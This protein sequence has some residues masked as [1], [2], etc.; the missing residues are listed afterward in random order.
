MAAEIESYVTPAYLYRYRPL[1]PELK[2]GG[3][4]RRNRLLEELDAI[5]RHYLF[6]S[7]YKAMN[8]PMEGMYKSTRRA[9]SDPEWGDMVQDIKDEKLSLGIA[10]FSETWDHELMWAHYANGFRGICVG[11]NVSKLVHT[12]PDGCALTRVSYGDR[13]HTLNVMRATNREMRARAVLSQ[14][15]VKWV[16][17]REWR[18]FVATA[19]KTCHGPEAVAHVY[20]GCRI[21]RS[22]RET[23]TARLQTAGIEVRRT[24]LH[25]YSVICK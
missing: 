23:V 24:R 3:K 1:M 12:L 19:G 4:V 17:E 21:P 16:Y 8:D 13:P 18:L 2:T 25:G 20:L 5:D 14:K 22:N 6:C 7:T 11:Y 10:S 9:R 15:S